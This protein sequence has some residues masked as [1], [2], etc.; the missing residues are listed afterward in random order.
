MLIAAFWMFTQRNIAKKFK[1][2]HI[3]GG[4]LESIWSPHSNVCTPDGNQTFPFCFKFHLFSWQIKVELSWVLS[5]RIV[6]T[7][8]WCSKNDWPYP[9]RQ[10]NSYFWRGK[11]PMW[12]TKEFIGG[13]NTNKCLSVDYWWCQWWWWCQLSCRW[14]EKQWWLC[15]WGCVFVKASLTSRIFGRPLSG[16][17]IFWRT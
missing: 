15:G 9:S 13:N 1:T 14:W 11:I 10:S 17:K 12:L 6:I 16:E 5:Y 2:P 3:F 8:Q 7:V 4:N